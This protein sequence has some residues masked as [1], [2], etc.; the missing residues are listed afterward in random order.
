M[1]ELKAHLS[2]IAPPLNV[3]VPAT[4]N[5]MPQEVQN[6]FFWWIKEELK[7]N[8]C[9]NLLDK[10]TVLSSLMDWDILSLEGLKKPLNDM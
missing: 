6:G 8:L 4:F 7:V 9:T 10:S 3:N 2:K 1:A 5:A